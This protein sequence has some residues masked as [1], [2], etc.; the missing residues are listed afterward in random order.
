MSD[1][2][3]PITIHQPRRFEF[4]AGAAAKVGEWASGEGFRRILVLTNGVIAGQADRMKL[5]GDIRVFSD[6]MPE[7]DTDNLAAANGVAAD[8]NPD[9]IIGFGGGSV[10][11]VA[12]LVTVLRGGVKLV[13][14]VGP[15]RVD[16][17]PERACPCSDHRRNRIG[18]R[19]PRAGHR[20]CDTNE[21]G[22][23]KPV[24]SRRHGG[25]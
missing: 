6:V 5:N 1:Y 19:H 8:F 21:G 9:L 13:D 20:F 25:A 2:A 3:R 23:R 10:M 18:I 4:G 11:D 17:P 22:R 16:R 12:K 15:N 24:S 7:P 14:V